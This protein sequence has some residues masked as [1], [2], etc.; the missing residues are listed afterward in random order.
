[1]ALAAEGTCISHQGTASA[2]PKRITRMSGFS[3]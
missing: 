3:R 2:V 1:V